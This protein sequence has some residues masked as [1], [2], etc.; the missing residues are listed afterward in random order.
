MVET[1][2]Y[3][4][5]GLLS[6]VDVERSFFRFCHDAASATTALQLFTSAQQ[7]YNSLDFDVLARAEHSIDASRLRRQTRRPPRALLHAQRLEWVDAGCAAR[8]NPARE[9]R[10]TNHERRHER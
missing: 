10:D 7:A 9:E 5:R 1:A 8:G 6:R 3:N 4:A 2:A